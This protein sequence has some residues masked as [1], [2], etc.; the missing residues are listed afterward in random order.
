MP[1]ALKSVKNSTPRSPV[2]APKPTLKSTDG[3]SAK[4]AASPNAELIKKTKIPAPVSVLASVRESRVL[5]SKD[6][7]EARLNLETLPI[8]M[9]QN[10]VDSTPPPK[11]ALIHRRKA[12]VATTAAWKAAL[13]EAIIAGRPKMARSKRTATTADW[14]AQLEAAISASK[15]QLLKPEATPAMWRAAL[16]DAVVAARNIGAKLAVQM[17]HFT[18]K[19]IHLDFGY[20]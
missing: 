17:Q 7:F 15:P 12:I 3:Q 13:A 14:K 10:I 18:T 16:E 11:E 20:I 9:A 5:S 8:V 6:L 1:W 2:D 19:D 4:R